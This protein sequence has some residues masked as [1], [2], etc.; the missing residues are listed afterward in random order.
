MER[1]K[2]NINKILKN[3]NLFYTFFI[4]IF[5]SSYV[6]KTNDCDFSGALL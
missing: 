3:I 4:I 5:F 1:K 6:A 2:K